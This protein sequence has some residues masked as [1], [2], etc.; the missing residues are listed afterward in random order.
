MIDGVLADHDLDVCSV[1]WAQVT[2]L[3]TT[4]H[5]HNGTQ[6]RMHERSGT[7]RD[8]TLRTPMDEHE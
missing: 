8:R 3:L 2:T 5:A 1:G 4:T 6:R 7:R